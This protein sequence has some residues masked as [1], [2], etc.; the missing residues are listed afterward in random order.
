MKKALVILLSLLMLC[1]LCGCGNSAPG[2]TPVPTPNPAELLSSGRMQ[3]LLD[4]M[5]EQYDYVLL[6]SPPVDLVV[7]AVALST[8]CEKAPCILANRS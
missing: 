8:N 1:S 2:A 5:R 4:M 3:K 7:D 6:D